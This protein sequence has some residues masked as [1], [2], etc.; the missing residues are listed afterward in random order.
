MGAGDR[1][2]ATLR[3]AT[4]RD[5]HRP[6]SQWRGTASTGRAEA[7]LPVPRR[8]RRPLAVAAG[9]LVLLASAALGGAAATRGDHA[10]AVLTL[11]RPVAAG[12]ALSAADL[13]VAHISGSGVHGIAASYAGQLAGQT[14]LSN[15]PAGTLLTPQMLSAASVPR[16]GQEVVAVAVKAGA[17]PPDLSPGRAVAVQRVAPADGGTPLPPAVLVPE[18][19]VLHVERDPATG[20]TVVSLVV[21]AGRALDVSQASASGA[22]SLALLPAG[23]R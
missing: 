17:F 18:A 15:L 13:R 14:A 9:T 7:R 8:P 4:V 6:R 16:A 10:V 1:V 5:G 12:H 20:V 19:M 2:T 11:A 21:D 22:V 3:D 23:S